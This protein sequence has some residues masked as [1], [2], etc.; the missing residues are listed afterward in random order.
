M[1][2]FAACG[3]DLVGVLSYKKMKRA[4]IVLSLH[5]KNIPGPY[6]AVLLPASAGAYLIILALQFA[7][8]IPVML[9]WTLGPRY[10]ED[11]MEETGAKTVIS[12]WR[13][14]DRLS[15]VDFGSLIEKV[16]LLEDIREE[17]SL[18][19]KLRG[20]FYSLLSVPAILRSLGLNKIDENQPAVILYTSGT[21]AKPKG[22][23]LTH[24]NIL[25]NQRAAIQCIQVN[26]R[27]VLY[28]IL[29]P[30]H[31]FGFSVVGLFPLFI[32]LKVA[33]YP[34]PTDGFAI[35]EGVER[36][37]VTLFCS[38][39]SFLKGLLNS[40]KV[41]QLKS[42]RWF[43]SGAEK[44]P[45]ELF[46]RVAKLETGATVIEGYGITECAP[47]LTITRSNLPPK[48]VGQPLPGIDVCTI[49]LETQER[50]PEGSE[51][52]ICVRGPNVFNGYLGHPRDPF[53]LLSGDRWYRTGDIGRLDEEKNLIISGR[54]KRF[55]KVGGEM[56][57]LGGV[58]EVLVKTFIEEGR[59]S[60]DV[61]SLAVIADERKEG[62]AQLILF[63]T[64]SISREEA[65]SILHAQGFSRL[66]KISFV[67]KIDEIPLMGT[68]KTD[69]RNLQSQL[70]NKA[71]GNAT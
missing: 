67:K 55:T 16:Q 19:M 69:Y 25:E 1:K 43:I 44:A 51:G 41:E 23:P 27:D 29:P 6:V 59:I 50:L 58:E 53:I 3:D 64:V 36:W 66:V 65:N 7:G 5:F 4:A 47:V 46:E 45:P 15:H 48:G 61:P 20:A 8:K 17:I 52:E 32:G 12:S 34:D 13:F 57:S 54:I 31:S 11:M 56:I 68:G 49:H 9:N 38:P 39:P 40:A 21:E 33:Y 22:V 24:R 28:G 18:G 10:L 62:Q 70:N 37:N 30:F 35:A 2:D 63:S 60:A 71:T 14:L 42:I 26:E